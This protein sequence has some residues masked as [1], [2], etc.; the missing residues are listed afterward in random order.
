MKEPW[1]QP[2]WSDR[3]LFITCSVYVV[4]PDLT[5][6]DYGVVD[7]GPGSTQIKC[8]R[9]NGGRAVPTCS[10]VS[11]TQGI[12][13]MGSSMWDLHSKGTV[14][15]EITSI[16]HLHWC[17]FIFMNLCLTDLVTDLVGYGGC[18]WTGSQTHQGF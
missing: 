6:F 13:A 11:T 7:E 9:K 2:R 17:K 8:G 4:L 12:H 10:R 5:D 18:C 15:N 1:S 14:C 3:Y 16:T